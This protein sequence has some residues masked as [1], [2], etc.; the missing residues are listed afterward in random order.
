MPGCS[1]FMASEWAA[2]RRAG[3]LLAPGIVWLLK[4]LSQ[5][6][7]ACRLSVRAEMY[8]PLVEMS[9]VSSVACA[10]GGGAIA[11]VNCGRSCPYAYDPHANHIP[12]RPSPVSG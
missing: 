4:Y 11:I 9:S 12:A 7:Q 2:E 10:S 5:V 1:W 8:M 6:Q 3:K